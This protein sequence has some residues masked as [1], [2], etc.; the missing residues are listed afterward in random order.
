MVSDS[1]A[2]VLLQHPLNITPNVMTILTGKS[3]A[4]PCAAL[5]PVLDLFSNLQIAI[6]KIS[7]SSAL[8]RGIG[9]PFML[10]ACWD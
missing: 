6:S 9:L 8:V 1:S 5:S 4:P 3:N 10:L 2:G 7:V